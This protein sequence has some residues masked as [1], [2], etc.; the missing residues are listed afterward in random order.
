MILLIDNFDSFTY[1]LYQMLGSIS[2][3]I[4]AVRNNAVS[5]DDIRNMNPA[6][7]VLSPGPGRPEDSGICPE[8]VKKLSGTCP[9]LGVCL[10]EQTIAWA[11]GATVGYANRICHGKQ[12]AVLLDITS[13]IFRGL[14]SRIK[15]AR[16]HSL[17]VQEQTLAGTGLR[18]TAKSDDGE[19]MAIEND[20]KKLFGVQFHPESVMTPEGHVILENFEKL[21]G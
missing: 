21:C 11:G 2:P 5:I 3:D 10:G 19:V 6:G 4:R 12:S 7:I 18:V 17:A 1:N 15:V 8:V 16:Y 20:E 13:P 14:P 9:I